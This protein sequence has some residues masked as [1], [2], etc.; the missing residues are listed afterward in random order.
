MARVL[1]S[2]GKKRGAEDELQQEGLVESVEPQLRTQPQEDS[3]DDAPEEVTLAAGRA[4]ADERRRQ[5]RSTVAAQQESARRK[6]QQQHEAAAERKRARE[7]AKEAQQEPLQQDR[8][9]QERAATDPTALGYALPPP[10]DL[11]PTELLKELANQSKCVALY[12]RKCSVQW[13]GTT[14]GLQ[15]AFL[16][17]H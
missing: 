1:R 10:E 7:A 16:M 14:S 11:L 8:L 13:F 17:A 4:Q 3:D 2:R 15:V 9:Q 5:E 6:R 12:R